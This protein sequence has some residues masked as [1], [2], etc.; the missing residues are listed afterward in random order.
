MPEYFTSDHFELLNKWKGQKRDDSN[1]EQN[2]A[3]EDLK[4]AYEVTEAWAHEVKAS[5]FPHWRGQ[6]P[7]ASDQPGQLVCALQPGQNLPVT[8]RAARVGLYGRD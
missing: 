3:Y 6:A 5:L 1:P 4:K 7:Q 8:R 2:R